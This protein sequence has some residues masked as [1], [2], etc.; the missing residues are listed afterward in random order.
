VLSGRARFLLA[1]FLL[2]KREGRH[3][4][5]RWE[6]TRDLVGL[7]CCVVERRKCEHATHEIGERGFKRQQRRMDVGV[8]ALSAAC[9][10][11]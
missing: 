3:T 10:N 8:Y 4:P 2:R 9:I 5:V 11:Q 7:W 1:P 6:E